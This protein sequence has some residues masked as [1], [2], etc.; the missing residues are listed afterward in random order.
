MKIL[1]I[2]DTIGHHSELQ[3]MPKADVLVHTGNFTKSGKQKEVFDFLEWLY[4]QPYKYKIFI[5]GCNDSWLY[6]NDPAICERNCHCLR[7][8]A[9]EIEGVRFHGIPAFPL[10]SNLYDKVIDKIPQITDVL[11]THSQPQIKRLVRGCPRLGDA[12]EKIR[13]RLHLFGSVCDDWGVYEY[14]EH[15]T[16]VNSAILDSNDDGHAS[17]MRPHLIDINGFSLDNDQTIN[18]IIQ[19][20]RRGQGRWIELLQEIALWQLRHPNMPK[21]I[22]RTDRELLELLPFGLYKSGC[23]RVNDKGWLTPYDLQSALNNPT[24]RDYLQERANKGE[25]ASIKVLAKYNNR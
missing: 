15:T 25:K 7:Y 24:V 14:Y 18:K 22:N 4:A 11:V 3:N 1:H 17:L 9:V 21:I 10:D 19:C 13:P 2:S 6:D 16:L 20:G 23:I 8:S 12:V 5:A